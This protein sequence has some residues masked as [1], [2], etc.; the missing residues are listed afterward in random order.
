[1]NGKQG[2]KIR[3]QLQ[4]GGQAS[5]PHRDSNDLVHLLINV[6]SHLFNLWDSPNFD[7]LYQ[8]L[9]TYRH[10]MDRQYG[11]KGIIRGMYPNW[12]GFPNDYRPKQGHKTIFV[13]GRWVSKVEKVDERL[14]F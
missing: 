2:K 14:P 5:H 8:A 4:T 3:R 1:M 6:K 9:K 10:T 11:T 13:D 12:T 7:R